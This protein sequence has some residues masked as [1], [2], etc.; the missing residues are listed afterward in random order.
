MGSVLGNP[1]C[2]PLR[3]GIQHIP[4]VLKPDD[5]PVIHIPP[6]VV[7]RNRKDLRG[8]PKTPHPRATDAR[9]RGIKFPI[10][11]NQDP[12]NADDENHAENMCERFFWALQDANYNV[13]G[14]VSAKG[15][16][17]ERYEYTPY[18]QRTVYSRGWKLP[19]MND[20]GVVDISDKIIW[21]TNQFSFEPPI[22]RADL[23][24]DGTIDIS[25][26][27]I[28]NASEF[29]MVDDDPLVMQPRLES[30]RNTER[31]MGA[32]TTNIC[33]IGHQGLMH[34]KEFGLIYNRAR[35][36]SPKLGRFLQRDPLGYVDGMSLYEYVG[37][38]P[39][40]R[41]DPS[42]RTPT[43]VDGRGAVRYMTDRKKSIALRT[44][45]EDTGNHNYVI[46]DG[47]KITP[48]DCPSCAFVWVHGYNNDLNTAKGN[49][50]QVE[51]EYTRAYKKQWERL[52]PLAPLPPAMQTKIDAA[53]K[54]FEVLR[55]WPRSAAARYAGKKLAAMDLP[56]LLEERVQLVAARTAK[57]EGC[58]RVYGFA[59]NGIPPGAPLQFSRA[60][61]AATITGRGVFPKF[62]RD[63][64]KTCPKT[65][66]HLGSHSLGARVILTALSGKGNGVS[67]IGH[68]AMA[69]PAVDNEVFEEGEEFVDAPRWAD[70]IHIGYNGNDRIVGRAVYSVSSLNISLGIGGVEDWDDLPKRTRE[71]QK[72]SQR[73][74]PWWTPIFDV[75]TRHGKVYNWKRTGSGLIASYFWRDVALNANSSPIVSEF[76]DLRVRLPQHTPRGPAMYAN[77]RGRRR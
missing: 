29:T 16:L 54:E 63:F 65:K 46:A 34:D 35:Y 45:A 4:R 23:N 31:S 10:S 64:K 42:G 12:I 32:E 28:Y 25:D 68:V 11:F 47:P 76:A 17:I 70:R 36:L 52:A 40:R 41:R 1:V 20:D 18:G 61:Q 55:K 22:C 50:A 49:L 66:I 2:R 13:L 9:S 3:E 7:V 8:K 59:W 73:E 75:V 6:V 48:D 37:S 51:K 67:G 44:R 71:R 27:I 60:V 72:I 69:V 15:D 26:K 53:R 58:C 38:G 5:L 62:I 57:P 33:N 30:F 14:I 39:V 74:Y 77:P 56:A 21:T 24:G 19:D 43:L